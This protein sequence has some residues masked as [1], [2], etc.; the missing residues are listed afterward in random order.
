MRYI[1]RIIFIFSIL[2]LTS[3]YGINSETSQIGDINSICLS[4]NAWTEIQSENSV[5]KITDSTFLNGLKYIKNHF[6][7]PDYIIYFQSEPKEIVGCD[8]YSIRVVYNPKIANFG[9]DGLSPQLSD[10]E[11]IRIRNRV[12]TLI[13][14]YTCDEGKIALTNEMNKPAIFSKEYYDNE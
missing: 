7:K 8:Y 10:K 5:D 3:C 14:K 2:I 12:L 11:Q 1:N 6:I 9:L 13:R 4:K